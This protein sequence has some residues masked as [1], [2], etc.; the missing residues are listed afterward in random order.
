MAYHRPFREPWAT[1]AR[2]ALL[3]FALAWVGWIGWAFL[4]GLF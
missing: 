2:V 3:L 4:K 1:L